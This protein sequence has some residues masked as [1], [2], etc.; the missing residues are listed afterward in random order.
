MKRNLSKIFITLFI[1][2]VLISIY[3]KNHNSKKDYVDL[4]ATTASSASSTRNFY[5]IKV[6]LNN[7]I[8]SP[9]PYSFDR[10]YG[11]SFLGTY[12]VDM[13][14]FYKPKNSN[15]RDAIFLIAYD[16]LH[17]NV[18]KTSIFNREYFILTD[19]K[20]GEVDTTKK[21]KT[22]ELSLEITKADPTILP[23]IK[24]P[25]YCNLDTDCS[26]GENVCSYGSYNKYRELVDL[27]GCE[28]VL[29]PQEDEKQLSTLCD[30]KSEYPEIKYNDSKCIS[31]KCVA[32]NRQVICKE[33]VLP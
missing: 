8:F 4:N 33:D 6:G 22:R 14:G 25:S 10:E 32:Q 15:Y 11:S 18:N 24:D 12:L 23:F 3:N 31:N 2:F 28:N 5:K 13:L 9:T 7:E 26:V 17:E 30:P 27:G 20:F 1:V 16:S 19:S 21:Y 29:Y